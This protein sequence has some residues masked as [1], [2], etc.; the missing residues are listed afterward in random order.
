MQHDQV[1]GYLVAHVHVDD[2]VHE[3]KADERDGEEDAAVL[4]NVRRRHAHH[5]LQVLLARDLL[6]RGGLGRHLA[7]GAGRCA[8]RTRRG[9][10]SRG[11]AMRGLLVG[12]HR[13]L[14]TGGQVASGRRRALAGVVMV[15]L[16]LG[17]KMH[18]LQHVVVV[19]GG[20]V[21][22][23]KRGHGVARGAAAAGPT[24]A[25]AG[26]ELELLLLGRGQRART[27]AARAPTWSAGPAGTPSVRREGLAEVRRRRVV[28]AYRLV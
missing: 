16:L 24:A 13:G 5:L 8:S 2:P 12:R 28:D 15:V 7:S 23:L 1:L 19:V 26:R 11:H 18:L 4:V 17:L 14:S 20:A 6:G 3:V 22:A 25:A 9:R 10:G 21:V 27:R